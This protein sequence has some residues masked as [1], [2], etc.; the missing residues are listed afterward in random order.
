MNLFINFAT[1]IFNLIKTDIN[2][3]FLILHE[4]NSLQLKFQT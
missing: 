4:E 1:K 2:F 3:N